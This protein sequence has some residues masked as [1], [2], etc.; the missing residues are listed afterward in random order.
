[1]TRVPKHRLGW[2]GFHCSNRLVNFIVLRRVFE[3]GGK[4]TVERESWLWLPNGTDR[5]RC[6]RR[7]GAGLGR[8]EGRRSLCCR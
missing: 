4:L 5:R 6:M 3:L 2:G 7:S 8:A 1:M